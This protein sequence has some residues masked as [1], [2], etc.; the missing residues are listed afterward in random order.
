[1]CVYI[2]RQIGAPN[3]CTISTTISN[4]KF[5]IFSVFSYI[6]YLW[7]RCRIWYITSGLCKPT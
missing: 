5:F 7:N 4:F 2:L 1:M 3:R 6:G